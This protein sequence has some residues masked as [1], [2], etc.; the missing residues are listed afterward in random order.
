MRLFIVPSWYPH[1]CFPFE[2]AFARDQALALGTL[3]PEWRVGLGLWNQG[4]GFVSPDHLRRSPRCLLRALAR[5]SE[6]PRTTP[7]TANVFEF[8]HAALATS[9]RWNGGNRQA[10]L[11]ASRR[12][13][14]RAS[15]DWGAIDV[16][17]AH[18][19][20]PGGWVAMQLAR[21]HRVPYVITEHM[22]PFPLAVY[23]RR[24]GTLLPIL[25]EPLANASAIVAVSG[26]LA[27]RIEQFG[28]P[29]PEVVPNVVDERFFAPAPAPPD[30]PRGFTFFLLGGMT[31]RKGVSELLQALADLLPRLSE[32]HRA[33]V[34]LRIGGDGPDLPRFRAEAQRLGLAERVSWLGMLAPERALEEFQRC[35][36]F[37]LPSR[38]ESFGIV[39]VEALACGKPVI[40]TRCGGPDEVVDD[41]NG[42]LLPVGDAAALR[43]ALAAFVVGAR[44]FDPVRLR[45]DA[46]ARFGRSA[47][48][49]R[50]E[51]VY[52]R[53]LAS[54]VTRAV[55]RA[56]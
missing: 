38:A 49:G 50:L 2:G 5:L 54:P 36:A 48:V 12:N 18:G 11:A 6:P 15:R 4:E 33:G 24:D 34:R 7:L 17:H 10:L 46:L 28:F 14:Q 42:V 37:V 30:T 53:V 27:R 51:R 39:Y 23:A 16:I 29:A 26:A 41:T 13:W 32:L 43:D 47:V 22:A 9:Q 35:D 45:A 52:E 19:S 31:A 25:A 1:A 3:R 8:E 55:G 56:D 21:E 44:H 40:A 20:Y